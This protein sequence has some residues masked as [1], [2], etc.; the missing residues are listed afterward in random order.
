MWK[1]IQQLNSSALIHAFSRGNYTLFTKR[2]CILASK[3]VSQVAV[4]G[5]RGETQKLYSR[6]MKLRGK[7]WENIFFHETIVCQY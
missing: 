6:L 2:V 5:A 1:A 3:M 7:F 4:I